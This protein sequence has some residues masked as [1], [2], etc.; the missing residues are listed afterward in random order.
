MRWKYQFGL[1]IGRIWLD[2]EA[3][4]NYTRPVCA[5]K[6]LGFGGGTDGQNNKVPELTGFGGR[7]ACRGKIQILLQLLFI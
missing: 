2:K 1:E 5:R 4:R 3:E 6:A 7:S